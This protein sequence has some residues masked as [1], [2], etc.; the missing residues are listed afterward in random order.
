MEKTAAY[1]TTFDDV[2]VEESIDKIMEYCKQNQLNLKFVI[3]TNLEKIAFEPEELVNDL[4]ER[5]CDIVVSDDINLMFPD[6]EG[7]KVTLLEEMKKKGIECINTEYGRSMLDLAH[8][9]NMKKSEEVSK[10]NNN[11]K[12]LVVYQGFDGYT[13]DPEYREI[14]DYMEEVLGD[15]D[16]GVLYFKKETN[17]IINAMKN[18]IASNPVEEIIFKEPFVTEE[19]VEFIR[20]LKMLE[21]DVNY[22]EDISHEMG[23]NIC[24]MN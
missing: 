21:I 7:F 6:V 10:Q 15:P 20:Q 18:I 4:K 8:Y 12:V 11:L 23:Q 5:K 16:Y 14:V 1:V 22:Y 17:E 2:Y 24:Q 13:E 19:G 3:Q 9:V